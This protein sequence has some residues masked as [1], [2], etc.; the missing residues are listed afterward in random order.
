MLGDLFRREP[1]EAGGIVVQN[2][3]FL[4]RSEERG[5]FDCLDTLLDRCRAIHLVR[6][7]HDATAKPGL[8]DP[9]EVTVEFLARQGVADDA[10]V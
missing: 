4:F 6:P 5:R 3:A 9:L 1:Q 2:I 8:D 7:E 10:D